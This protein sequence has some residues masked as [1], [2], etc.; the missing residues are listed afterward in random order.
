MDS[1]LDIE[2]SLPE[3]SI[4]NEFKSCELLV[5][6]LIQGFV[7]SNKDVGFTQNDLGYYS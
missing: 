7:I 5:E 1:I 2:E 4:D 6:K 3:E